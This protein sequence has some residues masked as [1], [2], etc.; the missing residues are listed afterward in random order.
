[1]CVCGGG[2]GGGG[3]VCVCVFVVYECVCVCVCVMCACVRVSAHARTCVTPNKGS[4]SPV[5]LSAF[6]SGQFKMASTRRGETSGKFRSPE[7]QID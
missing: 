6:N 1:M 2:G 4:P 5:M 3:G 7:T